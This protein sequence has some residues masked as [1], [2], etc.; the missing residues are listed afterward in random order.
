M[1]VAITSC[2]G[3]R[4]TLHGTIFTVHFALIQ[5]QYF[6]NQRALS[7]C[8]PPHLECGIAPLFSVC[9]LPPYSS[10]MGLRL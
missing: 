10:W 3:A 1:L 5:A 8:P 2:E 9:Y 4:Q 6:C 7:L